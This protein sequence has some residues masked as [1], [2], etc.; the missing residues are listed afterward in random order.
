MKKIIGTSIFATLAA[1]FVLLSSQ[2]A[3]LSEQV[4]VLQA[5]NNKAT[6]IEELP[7]QANLDTKK[8]Y[9]YLPFP[10]NAPNEDECLNVHVEKNLLTE[11][12]TSNLE[13]S[14]YDSMKQ[15]ND[16]NH[17]ADAIWDAYGWQKA[18]EWYYN[19]RVM[20]TL[21]AKQDVFKK[22][23]GSDSLIR[24]LA[25]TE[26]ANELPNFEHELA[27]IWSNYQVKELEK[28]IVD[29]ESDEIIFGLLSQKLSS[30]PHTI[31]NDP[32]VSPFTSLAIGLVKARRYSLSAKVLTE[33]PNLALR[34]GKYESRLQVS[35][36]KE[37][38][39]TE[40]LKSE[41]L[42]DVTALIEASNILQDTIYYPHIDLRF[43]NNEVVKD[44]LVNLKN[45]GFNVHYIHTNELK[46]ERVNLNLNLPE[47]TLPA[48]SQAKLDLC[49]EKRG[50]WRSR[51]FKHQAL[52]KFESSAFIKQLTSSPEYQYCQAMK[53][54]NEGIELLLKN[55]ELKAVSIIKSYIRE[56]NISS[57]DAVSLEDFAEK[58]VSQLDKDVLVLLLSEQ[59]LGANKYSQKEVLDKFKAVNLTL[60]NQH[61]YI[62]PI[63]IKNGGAVTLWLDEVTP[64]QEEVTLLLN[65][66]AEEAD[67][68]KFSLV[69]S[70]FSE[71]VNDAAELDHFYFFLKG[72]SSFSFSFGGN[73]AS[74]QNQ[75]FVAYFQQNGY[76]VEDHHRR[77][78]FKHKESNA[79]GY[80]F[81][82]SAF[83]DLEISTVPEYF[84]VNCL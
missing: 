67:F 60:S 20:Q 29:G 59:Y 52:D 4:D 50:W 7:K 53:N 41:E 15:G 46:P 40:V 22:L 79:E 28:A 81:L 84:E 2:E 73:D 9:K 70:K 25:L 45:K 39:I 72:F 61:L 5:N 49:K 27:M 12:F 10:A 18:Q 30:V 13:K 19:A 75:D 23:D 68:E 44:T 64:S 42:S 51:Q 65:A 56:N 62:L 3:V 37:L 57:L 80:Q 58:E 43:F 16:I 78:V 34:Q 1:L 21:H 24:R 8:V 74:R 54:S 38:G 66:L 48:D 76:R 47:Q 83:P 35:I 71:N 32:F 36:L 82:V 6:D 11:K 17:I 31:L 69:K 77:V 26:Q 55:K 63:F 33:Y 14:A